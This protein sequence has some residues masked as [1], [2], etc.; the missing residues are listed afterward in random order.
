MLC[1]LLLQLLELGAILNYK[2]VRHPKFG[3]DI[4]TDDATYTP[5]WFE[6]VCYS[7][8]EAFQEIKVAPRHVQKQ[9]QRTRK[10]NWDRVLWWLGGGTW[11]R[12]PVHRQGLAQFESSTNRGST[13]TFLPAFPD[14]E[15]NGKGSQ[16][17]R[18]TSKSGVRL[19]RTELLTRYFFSE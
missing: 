19:Y 15:H 18:H 17:S 3:S 12:I 4:K 16:Q 10:E 5:R 6:N 1:I 8:N 13:W 9:F 14:V 7:H 11:L 2:M